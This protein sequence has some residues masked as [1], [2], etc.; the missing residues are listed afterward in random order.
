MIIALFGVALAMDPLI[1][2][3]VPEPGVSECGESVPLRAG[4]PPPAELVGVDGLVR[5]DAVAEPISRLAY[6]L[7]VERHRDAI[8]EIHAVD[9]RILESERDWYRAAYLH[10][11]HP[12]WYKQPTVQRWT[13]RIETLATVAII[14]GGAAVIYNRSEE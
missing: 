6:L 1:R 14:V 5:C 13:G 2:P 3:S 4:R 12:P 11:T 8:E 10:N 7:A 9:L